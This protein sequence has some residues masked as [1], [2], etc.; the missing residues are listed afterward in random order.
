MIQGRSCAFQY[1]AVFLVHGV[2]EAKILSP[3]PCGPDQPPGHQA[4]PQ[5]NEGPQI[6]VETVMLRDRRKRRH[7]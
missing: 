4:E 3:S 6:D 1:P 5:V 7:Q 2:E